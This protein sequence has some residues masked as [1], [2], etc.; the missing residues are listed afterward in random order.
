V[1]EEEAL[2]LRPGKRETAQE[3]LRADVR[4]RDAADEHRDLAEELAAP[5]TRT[6][7]AVDEDR[8]LALEDDVEGPTR[9]ALAEN[10][11]PLCEDLLLERVR[12]G[13]ELGPA[14]IGEER[15]L[16]ETVD[17]GRSGHCVPEPTRAAPLPC[18][19]PPERAA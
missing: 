19:R 7:L 15:E 1:L 14:E 2:E 12:D 16:S 4:D 17:G 8:C 5:E 3:R 9:D 13:F 10:P 18:L 6:L 11:L